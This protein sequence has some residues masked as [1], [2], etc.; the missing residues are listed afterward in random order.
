MYGCYIIFQIIRV[1]LV[2]EFSNRCILNTT[3]Y[4][5]SEQ[6]F[7]DF[8]LSVEWLNHFVPTLNAFGHIFASKVEIV[9][10][11]IFIA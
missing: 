11:F 1:P 3:A 9:F 5:N 4:K 2:Y 10:I 7:D 8:Q 6:Y